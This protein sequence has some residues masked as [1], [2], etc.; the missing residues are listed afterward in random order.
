MPKSTWG[1]VALL[2]VAG[3]AASSPMIS[4]DID[5]RNNTQQIYKN[6][7]QAEVT[8]GLAVV[9]NCWQDAIVRLSVGGSQQQTWNV[10]SYRNPQR[11]VFRITVPAGGEIVLESHGKKR[12]A[13]FIHNC[14][15]SYQLKE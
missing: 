1:I 15:Y 3:C 9:N 8:L 2:V 7:T 11:Q 6:D 13:P 10:L 12:N 14:F 5:C 4:G